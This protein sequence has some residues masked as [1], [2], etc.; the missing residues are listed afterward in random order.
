MRVL[1]LNW[2]CPKHPEAGGAE[3]Y[4][5]EICKRLAKRGHKIL[6][7]SPKFEGCK[8]KETID[9]VNVVRMGGR[10]SIYIRAFLYYLFRLRGK[11]DVIIDDINGVPFFTPLYVK[12]NRVPIIHHIVGWEI[13]RKELPLILATIGYILEKLIPVI[14][15][16]CKIITVSKST[17]EELIR[18][19]VPRDNVFVIHNGIDLS[20]YSAG[21]KSK[22]PVVIYFGRVKRYKRVDHILEAFKL[23]IERVSDVKLVIAGRGDDYP[24]LKAFAKELGI[25]VELLG[26]VSEEEKIELLQKAWVYAITSE[27]EGWGI[28]VIEANACGTPVVAYDVPGLR[29]SVKHGYNGLLVENG[30]IN[31]LANA[32]T[33]LLLD[34]KLR[35]KMSKNAIEWAKRFSWDKSADEFER[36]IKSLV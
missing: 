4:L 14:Y 1:I 7:I 21:T 23:V 19:G 24:R 8:N 28:S 5:L 16:N 17:K 11:Y 30:N 31:E 15:R 20:R 12:E 35:K 10:F 3:E 33:K 26:E 18:F 2:K 27:K 36:L 13:F 29:D 9:G 22:R 32:L 34:Y 25:D 6:W